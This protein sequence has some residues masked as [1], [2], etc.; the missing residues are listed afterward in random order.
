MT[1]PPATVNRAMVG[2]PVIAPDAF[3]TGPRPRTALRNALL[4]SNTLIR[5]LRSAQRGGEVGRRAL[6]REVAEQVHAR[7]QLGVGALTAG[8]EAD[9]VV[10]VG[11]LPAVDLD[12]QN[13]L[14]LRARAG[15][16]R[17]GDLR[18]S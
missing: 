15:P 1:S 7:R 18:R 17:V 13:L 6:H 12:H 14:F 16:A 2:S 9:V 4:S 8:V 3:D 5:G 10:A 11:Q